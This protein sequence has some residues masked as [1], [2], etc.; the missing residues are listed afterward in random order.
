MRENNNF[1]LETDDA[2]FC[3]IND[4]LSWETKEFRKGYHNTIMQFQNQ[5]NLRRE[6]VFAECQ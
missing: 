3:E 1:V 2:P 5:Y 6:R 4:V